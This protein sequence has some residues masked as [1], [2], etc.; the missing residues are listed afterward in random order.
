MLNP[1]IYWSPK[2]VTKEDISTVLATVNCG[3]GW[4]SPSCA[5][6]ARSEASFSWKHLQTTLAPGCHQMSWR[7]CLGLLSS[8]SPRVKESQVTSVTRPF[9]AHKVSAF[10]WRERGFC[11]RSVSRVVPV[12]LWLTDAYNSHS[13]A[14]AR[15]WLSVTNTV[16][17]WCA[18]Y[19][20]SVLPGL[21]SH[22]T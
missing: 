4:S 3:G 7:S 16:L 5:Y 19:K 22:A 20:D 10:A 13:E 17:G 11:R 18:L 12:T 2:Y 14:A 15:C 21:V 8:V 9:S 6:Q 1:I